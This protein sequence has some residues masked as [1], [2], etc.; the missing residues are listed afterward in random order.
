MPLCVYMAYLKCL[1][2]KISSRSPQEHKR[3]TKKNMVKGS[4]ER[5][6]LVNTF[7]LDTLH[8]FMFVGHCPLTQCPAKKHMFERVKR[9]SDDCNKKEE[10]THSLM[11]LQ[12]LKQEML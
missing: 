9:I 6:F 8:V 11:F 7:L 4:Y 12:P 5:M 10:K 3:S 2:A 1:Q